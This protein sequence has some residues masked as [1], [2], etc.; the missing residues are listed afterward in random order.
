M[1]AEELFGKEYFKVASPL[2]LLPVDYFD[3]ICQAANLWW[4]SRESRWVVLGEDTEPSDLM[5]R[6][7]KDRAVRVD[8][9]TG[10]Y[11]NSKKYNTFSKWKQIIEEEVNEEK[12]SR[13]LEGYFV[14]LSDLWE[15]IL[16]KTKEIRFIKRNAGGEAE[17]TQTFNLNPESLK[18]RLGE[19]QV[20]VSDL[21]EFND[22]EA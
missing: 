3:D 9:D 13:G 19:K 21:S 22:L 14:S 12:V 8:K 15:L 4:D 2:G 16:G 10:K 20:R 5:G 6:K 17:D 11:H 18:A 1:E 7:F